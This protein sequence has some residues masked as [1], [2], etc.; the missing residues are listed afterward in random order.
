MRKCLS[1]TVFDQL[2]RE[3]CVSVS[4]GFTRVAVTYETL[5]LW[6]MQHISSIIS[7]A[8]ASVIT[9]V[10]IVTLCVAPPKVSAIRIGF[11]WAGTSFGILYRISW[12]SCNSSCFVYLLLFPTDSVEDSKTCFRS[13]KSCYLHS[14]CLFTFELT[15]KHSKTLSTLKNTQ[16]FSHVAK[17]S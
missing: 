10:A 8:F 15:T 12:E 6:R 13:N 11:V 7:F 14:T 5:T 4:C 3:H 1:S 17:F 2:S 16:L 9:S